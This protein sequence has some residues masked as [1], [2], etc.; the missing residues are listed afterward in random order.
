LVGKVQHD[1]FSFMRYR[2][3][4]SARGLFGQTEI[5]HAFYL[6]LQAHAETRP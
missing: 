1:C 3:R 2:F 4:I 5:F 6:S